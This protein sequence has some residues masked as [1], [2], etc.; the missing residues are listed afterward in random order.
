MRKIVRERASGIERPGLIERDVNSEIFFVRYNSDCEIQRITQCVIMSA[1]NPSDFTVPQLKEK[2]RE[3]G[4]SVVGNKPE[5][6][7]RLTEADPSGNWMSEIS[8][9][10][11]VSVTAQGSLRNDDD[12]GTQAVPAYYEREIEIY[13]REKELAEREL[14][15][16]QRELEIVRQMQR[17][18][19]VEH[20]QVAG[21]ENYASHNLPKASI[22]AIADL[23]SY[24]D[25][26]VGGYEAWKNS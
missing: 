21:R 8:E 15:F 18:N 26:S 17:L 22:A 25:G 11:Q 2:L 16:A 24:F 10:P 1:K 14:Q 13:R 7:G 5:L 23:P 9:M 6:I 12:E 19:V 20:D 3:L 4:L